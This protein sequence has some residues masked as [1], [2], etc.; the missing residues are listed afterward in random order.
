MKFSK[1]TFQPAPKSPS[2]RERER[3]ESLIGLRGVVLTSMCPLGYLL[4]NDRIEVGLSESL[5]IPS[6]TKVRI[7]ELKLNELVVVM[8][9][10]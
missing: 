7:T 6:G 9:H 8:D 3:L 4:V 5:P 1:I 2:Q 10:R